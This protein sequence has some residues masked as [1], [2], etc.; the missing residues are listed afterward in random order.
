MATVAQQDA[1][2]TCDQ[3]VAG[4][5]FAGLPKFF[6]EIDHEI[7]SMVIFCLLLIQEGQL[8]ISG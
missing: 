6:R 5:A 7:F 2:P 4:L 3:D 1:H 8:S